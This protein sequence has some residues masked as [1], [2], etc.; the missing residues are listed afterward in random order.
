MMATVAAIFDDAVT[1]EK[2]VSQLQAA[3]LGDDIIEVD[4]GRETDRAP[5]ET[6][7]PD[8]TQRDEGSIPAASTF[9]GAGGSQGA[10]G[11]SFL[12][13][14]F[15]GGA[16]DKL[17]GLGESAEPFRIALERGGKLLV[18]ETDSV[19]RVVS[20]L[21]QAGAQQLYDPRK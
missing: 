20:T 14:L 2:A 15:G 21:Q 6:L 13:G 7:T 5:E 11:I 18:L 1:L 8:D 12:G 10:A 4:E 17:G 19:E 16:N 9:L 3:G